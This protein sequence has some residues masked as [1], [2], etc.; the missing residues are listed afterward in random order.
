MDTNLVMLLLKVVAAQTAQPATSTPSVMIFTMFFAAIAPT[1]AG[2]AAYLQARAA[3]VDTAA[4][5]KSAFDTA[6]SVEK[7]HVAVNSERT[8]MLAE[9]KALKDE[10][11][12]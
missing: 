1:L 8:A 12:L 11:F 4:T 10:I 6:T 5:R 2:V 7:V 3:K 9:V